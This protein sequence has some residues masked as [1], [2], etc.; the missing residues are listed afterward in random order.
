[1]DDNNTIID[2]IKAVA[3]IETKLETLDEM[4]KD[5]KELKESQ[6]THCVDCVTAVN[7]REHIKSHETDSSTRWNKLTFWLPFIVSIGAIAIAVFK[8][9]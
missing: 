3:R 4:K 1:M 2:L 8:K 5:I 9:G 6:S 7:L